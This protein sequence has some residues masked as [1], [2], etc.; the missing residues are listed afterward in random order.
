MSGICFD[1]Y[2]SFEELVSGLKSEKYY[3]KKTELE[4]MRALEKKELRPKEDVI[5]EYNDRL[6]RIWE[7]K[8][9]ENI[10]KR[11]RKQALN[12]LLGRVDG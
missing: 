3:K 8:I 1:R 9:S 12:Y 5:N 7:N 10:P 2:I 4:A 11:K 6:Y